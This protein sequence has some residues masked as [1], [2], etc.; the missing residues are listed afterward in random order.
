MNTNNKNRKKGQGAKK[1]AS[2]LQE[3]GKNH[4]LDFVYFK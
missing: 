2:A 1:T 4:R 3:F